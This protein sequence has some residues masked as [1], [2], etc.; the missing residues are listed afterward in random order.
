MYRK[1]GKIVVDKK[2]NISPLWVLIS[3]IS[4]PAANTHV[5]NSEI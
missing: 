1:L 3:Y 2:S 5:R 4:T